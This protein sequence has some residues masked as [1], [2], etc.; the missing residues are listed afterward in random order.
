[1][2]ESN[3]L[4]KSILDY[5]TTQGHYVWRQNVVGRIRG[6]KIGHKR[7]TPDVIGV[8]MSGKFIGVEIKVGADTQSDDQKAFQAAV[9]RRGGI[10]I[11]AG[12]IDDVRKKI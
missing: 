5:L 9:E 12:S 4:T 6:R 8:M 11:L 2:T 7:G 1:M 10:Y 3:D